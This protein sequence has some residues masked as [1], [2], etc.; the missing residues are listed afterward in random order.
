M[1]T[2]TRQSSYPATTVYIDLKFSS[3][4]LQLVGRAGKSKSV[5]ILVEGVHISTIACSHKPFLQGTCGQNPRKTRKG[6]SFFVHVQE[7]ET[8]SD[9]HLLYQ[10]YQKRK[11]ADD[12]M[13]VGG[14]GG[15]QKGGGGTRSYPRSVPLPI[16]L[17]T[18]AG[19]A[20][21]EWTETKAKPSGSPDILKK[22]AKHRQIS[23]SVDR[24]VA[25]FYAFPLKLRS[26]D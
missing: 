1:H 13:T 24:R 16:S 4:H 2:Y 23:L 19:S 15:F 14:G 22:E 3:F 26:L 12:Q 6:G 5:R 9:P 25:K 21:R 11:M 20:V 8:R 10:R 18:I 17:P 7:E